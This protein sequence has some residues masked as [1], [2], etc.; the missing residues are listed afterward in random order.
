MYTLILVQ[1]G[2][3]GLLSFL[4]IFYYQIKLSFR[5]SNKFIRDL[6]FT[7][8][9]LFL[10]VM[11]GESYLLGHFTTLMYIFFSAFLYKNFEETQ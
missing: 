2:S 1:L 6:G 4:S 3:V 9:L 7:L 10:V 8:P 5:S 11:F